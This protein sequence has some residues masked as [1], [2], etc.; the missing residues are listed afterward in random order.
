MSV[1]QSP[2]DRLRDPEHHLLA[3]ERL[4]RPAGDRLCDHERSL[5]CWRT[6]LLVN[7]RLTLLSGNRLC[8]ERLPTG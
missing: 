1:R 5:T 6:L 8:H 4:S 3:S 2:G 7:E